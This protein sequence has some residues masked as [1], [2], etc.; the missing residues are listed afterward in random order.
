MNFIL[1]SKSIVR[2]FYQLNMIVCCCLITKSCP[3]LLRLPWT[4]AHQTPLSVEF[5]GKN[6]GVGC[7]F[8]L[9]GIFPTQGS[10]VCLR[11]WQAG[12]FLL[13]HQG[14]LNMTVTLFKLYICTL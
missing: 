13:S 12:P 4:V 11:Y 3:I 2:R 10:N 8:L 7:R 9:Q 14:S 5:L 1:G 6:I